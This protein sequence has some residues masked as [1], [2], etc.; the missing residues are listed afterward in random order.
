MQDNRQAVSLDHYFP[1]LDGIRCVSIFMV[2]FAHWVIY[3]QLQHFNLMIGASAVNFFFTLSGFLIS[4]ILLVMKVTYH[5]NGWKLFSSFYVRRMLRIFPLYYMVVLAGFLFN[6]PDVRELIVKLVTFTFN[7]PNAN[8]ELWTSNVYGHFWSLSA[9]EQFYFFYPILII[10]SPIKHLK[11]LI[12]LLIILGIASRVAIYLTDF[13]LYHKKW[14]VSNFTP[15]CFDSFGLGGIVAW[16]YCFET[17]KLKKLFRHSFLK[18]FSFLF[19]LITAIFQAVAPY[20]PIGNVLFRFSSSFFCAWII[21]GSI[22]HQLPMF[23]EKFLS[24]RLL[25]Y[26][27]KI[28]FGLYVFHLIVQWIIFKVGLLN[29]NFPLTIPVYALVYTLLTILVAYL[30]WKFFEHPVNNLKRYFPY[31]M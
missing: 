21:T 7:I 30:S 11:G 31:K 4:R 29:T 16:L 6:L 25:V 9:E 20:D 27:G 18:G 2:F 8:L 1:E 28:S 24:Q 15:C 5:Q 22:L 26:L 19:F 14:A 13:P 17:E 3:T 23:L 10:L 12:A